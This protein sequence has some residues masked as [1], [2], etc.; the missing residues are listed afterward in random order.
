M[1]LRHP[2]ITPGVGQHFSVFLNCLIAFVSLVCSFAGLVSGCLSM[3]WSGDLFVCLF[4][5]SLV[6]LFA[7]LFLSLCECLRVCL[8]AG[9][10]AFFG[11]S[12]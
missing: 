12:A 4:V 2:E 3:S 5:R 10:L 11:L 8:L 9:E 6:F 7:C 1:I